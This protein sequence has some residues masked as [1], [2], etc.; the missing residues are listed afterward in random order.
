MSRYLLISNKTGQLGNRLVVY[1]HMLAAA[2][3]RG[4]TLL[5]P[6]FCEYA[7]YFI[8]TQGRLFECGLAQTNPP[9][10]SM[11][12][13]HIFYKINRFGYQLS[14]IFN[15]VPGSRIGWA[16]VSESLFF[17]LTTLM[18]QADERG[19]LFLFTQNYHFRQHQWCARHADY[20][21]SVFTPVEPYQQQ[22]K[23]AVAR[24]RDHGDVLVGVH[25]R[26]GDYR[27]HLGGKYY[28][29]VAQYAAMMRQIA[30]FLAPQ[31]VTFLVCSNAQHTQSD[32]LGLSVFF[33]PG[34][35]VSDLHALSQCDWLIGPPSSFS[36]W[37]AFYG[38]VR[39][40]M[41]EDPTEP[42]TPTHFVVPPSPDPRY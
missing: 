35:L 2:R 10:I 36:A 13:R 8:G 33:G 42:I 41:V 26:H 29:S 16:K 28:F 23:A 12:D 9:A 11:I 14:K 40:Y 25:I 3:E 6:S 38:A 37:A 32:F 15:R 22:A 39:F 34:H 7:P 5:N 1:A 4:W 30:D 20:L 19:L 18:D 27:E 17:D 31:R 21:R 24:A